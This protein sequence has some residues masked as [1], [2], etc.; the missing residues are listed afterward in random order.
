MKLLLFKSSDFKRQKAFVTSMMWSLISVIFVISL[1]IPVWRVYMKNESMN[2][3]IPTFTYIHLY[4]TI[5][6]LQFSFASLV[7]R[8]RFQ[9]LNDYLRY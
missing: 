1:V 5:F 4:M 6:A 2:S 7:V 3:T 9:L 8:E